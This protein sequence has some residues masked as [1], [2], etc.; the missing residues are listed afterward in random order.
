LWYM[1][2]W[3]PDGLN[4]CFPLIRENP[5]VFTSHTHLVFCQINFQ[6]YS[7]INARGEWNVMHWRSGSWP[8]TLCSCPWKRYRPSQKLLAV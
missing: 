5:K 1:F 7:F 6:H 3:Y 4:L 2:L 8:W